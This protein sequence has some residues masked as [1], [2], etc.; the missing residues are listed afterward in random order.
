[1][2]VEII[3]WVRAL[4]RLAESTQMSALTAHG[5]SPDNIVVDGRRLKGRSAENWAWLL[6]KVRG[7]DTL[8]VADLRTLLGCPAAKGDTLGRGLLACIRDIE[9]AGVRIVEVS[10]GL[11][12]WNKAER[13]EAI[14]AARDRMARGAKG[15]NAGR[16][17]RTFSAAQRELVERHW[18]S[19]GYR[20]DA[21]AIAAIQAEAA[22]TGVRGLDDLDYPQIVIRHF[23]ASGRSALRRKGKNR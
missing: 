19:F 4:P 13:D 15:G 22:V 16:L 23:G 11:R 2:A 12:L 21:E 6:R 8:A 9:A 1:M 10:S 14:L 7:G 20:T 5:V 17:K 18:R 3:G